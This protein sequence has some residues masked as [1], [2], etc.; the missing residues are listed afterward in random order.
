MF[1]LIFL[2]GGAAAVLAAVFA[3][4]SEGEPVEPVP[5]PD[6]MPQTP[7]IP[8]GAPVQTDANEVEALARVIGSEAGSGPINEQR[9]VAWTVRN[10]FRAKN[11][12][13]YDGE[14]PWRAQKG[15]NPPF[16]SARDAND[17]HRMLA[18]QVLSSPQSEDPTGG[19]T[20]FFEPRMQD[21]FFKAG[22]LARA[23]QTGARN[24]DGVPLSD[25]TRFKFYKKDAN[26][27]RAKWGKGSTMYATAGRFEFWGS[28]PLFARRGGQV[29]TIVAGD[30]DYVG[31]NEGGYTDIPDPLRLLPKY[32]RA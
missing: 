31:A 14:Y 27:I 2:L 5:L 29:K 24:I 1:P 16:S 11:K 12:S 20:S 23:G 17:S 21:A 8:S 15:G 18:R 4:S 9:A 25:I 28:A 19:A 6:D 7:V 26:Q 30:E 10:H 13:I 3:G 22:E 32:R